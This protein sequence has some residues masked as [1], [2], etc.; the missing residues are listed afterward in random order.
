MKMK[1]V[2]DVIGNEDVQ[3]GV[4]ANEI[5]EMEKKLAIVPGLV[6]HRT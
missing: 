3:V 2:V 5:L 6:G 4:Q 1:K